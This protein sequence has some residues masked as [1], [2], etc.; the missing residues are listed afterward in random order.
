MTSVGV[1]DDVDTPT[2]YIQGD[3]NQLLANEITS[4][5]DD[6]SVVSSLV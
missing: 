4:A 3:D 2:P 1:A 6:L 5:N